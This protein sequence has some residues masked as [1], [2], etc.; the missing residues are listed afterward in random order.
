MWMVSHTWSLQYPA[1][2]VDELIG[3][4]SHSKTESSS[5]PRARL[6]K[7]CCRLAKVELN[8]CSTSVCH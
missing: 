5:G 6:T 2:L 7:D 8:Q 3:L 4:M 1:S